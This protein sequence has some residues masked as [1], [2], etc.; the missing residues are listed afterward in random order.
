VAVFPTA[1]FAIEDNRVNST[2]DLEPMKV[3]LVN[4]TLASRT[5]TEIVTRDLAVGLA[6]TA[7]EACVFSPKLGTIANEIRA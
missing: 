2:G 1:T 4:R 7:H 3:L 6:G 5:G